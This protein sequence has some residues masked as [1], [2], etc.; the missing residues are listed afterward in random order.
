MDIATMVAINN[1]NMMTMMQK[2]SVSRD[3]NDKS[4]DF[5]QWK[6]RADYGRFNVRSVYG[7][8]LYS[9]SF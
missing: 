6:G 2:P 9:K 1:L 4:Y 3:T 8:K 7:K 5:K